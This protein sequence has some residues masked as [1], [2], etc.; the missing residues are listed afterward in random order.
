MPRRGFHVG[1]SVAVAHTPDAGVHKEFDDFPGQ[2]QRPHEVDGANVRYTGEVA[3]SHA[4]ERFE[5]GLHLPLPQLTSFDEFA[6]NDADRDP[7]MFAGGARLD[8]Y[9]ALPRA[10]SWYSGFGFELAGTPAAYGVV[11]RDLG[12]AGALSLTG[13]VFENT[14]AVLHAQVAYAV[15][16]TGGRLALFAALFYPTS[17]QMD[18]RVDGTFE[19][20]DRVHVGTFTLLG[21]TIA[22]GRAGE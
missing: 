10:R 16:G 14:G 4:W 7:T 5:L 22:S 9:F 13:R 6:N 19:Q 18:I 17:G 20:I 3:V 21:L 2:P 11:T 15:P 1:A 12:A 8:F